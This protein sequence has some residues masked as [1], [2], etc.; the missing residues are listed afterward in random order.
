MYIYYNFYLLKSKCTFLLLA[1][2]WQGKSTWSTLQCAQGCCGAEGSCGGGQGGG[3][4]VQ[5][6]LALPVISRGINETRVQQVLLALKLLSQDIFLIFFSPKVFNFQIT[7]ILIILFIL[8]LSSRWFHWR[9]CLFR[10]LA[11]VKHRA[12]ILYVPLLS[13][14]GSICIGSVAQCCCGDSWC[15]GWGGDEK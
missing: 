7:D 13:S 9:L 8:P 10:N 11:A 15:G 4:P 12:D 5:Q 1:T 3:L 6:E 14:T 2:E